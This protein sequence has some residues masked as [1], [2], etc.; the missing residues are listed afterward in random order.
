M[1]AIYK[2]SDT[3]YNTPLFKVTTALTCCEGNYLLSKEE[4]SEC[5]KM[6]MKECTSSCC[7]KG[8]VGRPI[9]FEYATM[10]DCNWS[11]QIPCDCS[12]GKRPFV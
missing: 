3:Y 4:Q 1:S 6:T 11:N 9:L 10:S 2:T 8:Y 12:H 7:G 5:D